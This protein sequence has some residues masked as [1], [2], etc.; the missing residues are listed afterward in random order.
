MNMKVANLLSIFLT[1][2]WSMAFTFS[3]LERAPK[4][5]KPPT[6]RKLSTHP[7]VSSSSF[8]LENSQKVIH[9]KRNNVNYVSVRKKFRKWSLSLAA[10]LTAFFH[11]SYIHP[12][13]AVTTHPVTSSTRIVTRSTTKSASQSRPRSTTSTRA[14][15]PSTA[16]KSIPHS[17]SK[18]RTTPITSTRVGRTETLKKSYSQSPSRPLTA[19]TSK[20]TASTTTR[21]TGSLKK[22]YSYSKSK[23]RSTSTSTTKATSTTTTKTR[24]ITSIGASISSKIAPIFEKEK[25]PLIIGT[26]AATGL[27]GVT[28]LVANKDEDEDGTDGKKNAAKFNEIMGLQV[29]PNDQGVEEIIQGD[30]LSSVQKKNSEEKWVED[31]LNYAASV[32]TKQ[33]DLPKPDPPK[34]NLPKTDHPKSDLPKTDPP[35]SD[36]PKPDHPK[37]DLPKTDHPKSDLSKP[38]PPNLSSSSVEKVKITPPQ[39]NIQETNKSDSLS[40]QRSSIDSKENDNQ[41]PPS[42]MKAP[43]F[44]SFVPFY[45]DLIKNRS[46][47]AEKQKSYS[48]TNE[49]D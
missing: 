20:S 19:S 7:L 11:K 28:F 9:R 10:L 27:L 16:K 26:S 3:K 46:S 24:S 40:V 30:R 34:S 48:K 18:P 4:F 15:S 12:T 33:N 17:Q 43:F 21:S 29:F 1:I 5:N 38:D 14:G 49:N 47:S 6:I 35:K 37:S 31:A 2:P 22:E 25:M 41:N 23:P 13:N 32:K 36:L 8:N 39:N 45:V 44:A 42:N